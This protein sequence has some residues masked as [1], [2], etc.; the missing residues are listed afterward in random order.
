MHSWILLALLC[1]MPIQDPPPP[2]KAPVPDKAAQE[3]LVKEI[4]GLMKEEYAKRDVAARKALAEKLLAEAD[5]TP[6]KEALKFVFLLEARD[7]AAEAGVWDITLSAIRTLSDLYDLKAAG[8]EYAP[9][10]MR[11]AAIAAA[12]KAARTAEEAQ[13]LAAGCVRAAQEA[14]D[15]GDYETAEE[16][17]KHASTAARTS[18]NAVLQKEAQDLVARIESLKREFGEVQKADAQLSKNPADP[19]A[20]LA[21]GRFLCFAKDDWE[22]GLPHLAKGSD[23]RLQAIADKELAKPE[24]SPGQAAMGDAWFELADK[25]RKPLLKERYQGRARSWFEKALSG[26]EGVAR[27]RIERRL[28]DFPQIVPR[29]KTI[30]VSQGLIGAWNLDEGKGTKIADLSPQGNQGILKGAGAGGTWVPGSPVGRF[31]LSFDGSDDCVK[32]DLDRL[33]NTLDKELTVAAWVHKETDQPEFRSVVSRQR[34]STHL[35]HFFL[36]FVD[37]RLVCFIQTDGPE[38][39]ADD[40]QPEFPR[41]QWI[42][43]ALAYNG[44]TLCLYRDGKEAGSRAASG[45]FQKD[46]NPITIGGD[47]NGSGDDVTN[48]FAGR[49]AGVRV[50]RRALSAAGVAALAARER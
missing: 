37:N 48:C 1:L 46:S 33:W 19:E 42:H 17:A 8:P 47:E 31:A 45:A 2:S 18:R 4:K 9:G 16:A 15:D 20:N 12:R 50:Y 30:P 38:L 41:G 7:V 13:A 11:L 21:V 3:S 10:R 22:R 23:P 36:G 28:K 29:P 14:M 6:L 35:N 40:R 32:I 43:I 27:L 26:A 5:R 34:G 25:E 49:I 44:T 24:D 39:F